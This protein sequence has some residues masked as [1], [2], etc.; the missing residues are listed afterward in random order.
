M[1]QPTLII[2]GAT[3]FIGS[4][5]AHAFIAKGYRVIGVSRT[6]RT[7][8]FKLVNVDLSAAGSFGSIV[9]EFSPDLVLNAAGVVPQNSD[10]PQ[11]H[12]L[13]IVKNVSSALAQR[14]KKTRLVHLGTVEE[15][16]PSQRTANTSS[17]IE[18][19]SDYALNKL[20]STTHLRKMCENSRF[21]CVVLRPT[22]IFGP[23][24]TGGMF[25][26]SLVQAFLSG[27]PF[28]SENGAIY[29][30]FLYVRDLVSCIESAFAAKLSEPFTLVEVGSGVHSRLHEVAEK[31]AEILSCPASK[32]VNFR[33]IQEAP[34]TSP[35]K[36]AS[37]AAEVLGFVPRF[38]LR[39]GLAETLEAHR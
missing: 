31:A 6:P 3:G 12:N 28:E 7:T 29:R 25:I 4:F 22:T 9:Q 24:Q 17:E 1:K 30:D 20:A 14:P 26:P 33:S 21:E 37:T 15:V 11:E 32:L 5:A 38:D 10:E 8:P 18:F 35:T 13:R 34:D 39:Q 27:R 19:G 23:G 36:I 16:G 2:A